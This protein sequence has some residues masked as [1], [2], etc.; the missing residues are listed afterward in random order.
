MNRHNRTTANLS[1]IS[2]RNCYCG[3]TTLFRPNFR[4]VGSFQRSQR[5][6]LPQDIRTMSSVALLAEPWSSFATMLEHNAKRFGPEAA[7]LGEGGVHLTHQALHDGVVS[8]VQALNRFGI[9]RGDRVAIVLPQGPDL[10]V[11]FL[12]VAAGATAVPLNPAYLL[13]DFEFYLRDSS[14]RA[15]L[16]LRGDNS[17]ARAAAE[18]VRMPVLEL[19]PL[20]E[21]G[22]LSELSGPVPHAVGAPG[23]ASADETALILHTSGTT[24]LPKR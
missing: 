17:P 4:F 5:G 13:K 6:G 1:P 19:I 9:G 21:G 2:A 3:E 22:G 18:M 14:A 15:L 11:A 16:V 12:A 24:A 7:I 23:F 20:K 10:A 8:A